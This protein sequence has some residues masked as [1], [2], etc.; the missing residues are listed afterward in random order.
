MAPIL[1]GTGSGPG[2][3]EIRGGGNGTIRREIEI[4]MKPYI[5]A[6]IA[7]V[8]S[9]IVLTPI[10]FFV[11]FILAGPHSDLLPSFLQPVVFLGGWV[12]LIAVPFWCARWI[13][14]RAIAKPR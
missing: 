4:Q 7:F 11:V 10:L 13:Y 12:S 8:L 3:A 5:L 14:R 9:L 1:A 2:A 6:T